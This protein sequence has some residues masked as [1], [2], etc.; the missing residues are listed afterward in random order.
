MRTW[1]TW[2]SADSEFGRLTVLPY[3]R[4]TNVLTT[5]VS[6][7]W[8]S[9][10]NLQV[11]LKMQLLAPLGTFSLLGGAGQRWPKMHLIS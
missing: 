11:S 7:S 9:R 1:A 3:Q 4:T 2:L 8:S 6:I 5:L 10:G